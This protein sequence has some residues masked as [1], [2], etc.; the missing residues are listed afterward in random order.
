MRLALMPPDL[1]RWLPDPALRV[2]HRR[3]SRVS[4][5]ELWDAARTVRVRDTGLLGRLIHWR[6]PGTSSEQRFDELFS[7][8]PFIELE[9]GDTSLVSGLVGRIWTLRRDYPALS[10][11]EEFREFAQ[12]GTAR[13]IFAT[14]I[15][16]SALNV[17]A[18]VETFG[19]R[20]RVGLAA[21]RPL[22]SSFQHLIGSEGIEAAVRAAEAS[23]PSARA[24]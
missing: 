12:P 14:W 9:R 6:I 23:A 1:D 3:W 19:S 10:D 22:I 20:G 15:S 11:P 21:V 18:R 5:E 2:A 17:E 24:R 4:P 13:V 7:S 16:E 8:P